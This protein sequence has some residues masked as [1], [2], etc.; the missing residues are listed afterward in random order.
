MNALLTQ[1]RK[2]ADRWLNREPPRAHPPVGRREVIH[3]SNPWHAVS[4]EPVGEGCEAVRRV[5]GQRFLSSE[6][7]QTPLPGCGAS[8]CGCRYRHYDDRRS[9]KEEGR[10]ANGEIP[11]H[12]RRRSTD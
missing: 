2:S 8:M 12:P 6:A 4:I 5:R 10:P 9:G 3:V 7:P 11:Y 1:L